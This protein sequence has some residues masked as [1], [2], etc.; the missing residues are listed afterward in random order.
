MFLLHLDDA[1][2]RRK[3]VDASQSPVCIRY[4]P[5][6]PVYLM[7]ALVRPALAEIG[8]DLRQR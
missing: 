7:E 5:A 6:F 4:G 8:N 1:N 3:A 2:S